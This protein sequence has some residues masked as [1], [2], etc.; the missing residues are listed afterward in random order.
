MREVKGEKTKSY[1]PAL[2]NLIPDVMEAHCDIIK[3]ESIFIF[4]CSVF[5]LLFF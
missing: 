4:V 5:F 3:N 2:N 1:I